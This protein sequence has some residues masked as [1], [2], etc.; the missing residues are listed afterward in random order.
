MQAV[1]KFKNSAL[2]LIMPLR[3]HLVNCE[4]GLAKIHPY[5]KFELSSFIR[6]KFTEGGLK[7]KICHWTLTT[8]LF[9]T[10]CHT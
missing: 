1:P 9:G 8:P 7:F 2:D 4:M 10:F 3:W 6:S 5:T